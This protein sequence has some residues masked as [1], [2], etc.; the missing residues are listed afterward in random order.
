MIMFKIKGIGVLILNPESG[1]LDP[2]GSFE[3]RTREENR[4]RISMLILIYIC[5][6]ERPLSDHDRKIPRVDTWLT[7]GSLT[8]DSK[9]VIVHVARNM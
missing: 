1:I 3:R 7:L 4:L 5:V 8:Y 9:Q 6:G 2:D